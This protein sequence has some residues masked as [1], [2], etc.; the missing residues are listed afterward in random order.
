M[1][2]LKLKKTVKVV[3]MSG[4]LVITLITILFGIRTKTVFKNKDDFIY[5]NDYIFDNYLPVIKKEEVL[6]KPFSSDNISIYKSFYD[7]DQSKEKQEKSLIY[8]ENI[9]M[10]N[11]GV[12]YSSESE[13]NVVSTISGTVTNISEDKLLGK[14]IEIKNSN[15]I[16]TTYQSLSEINVKKSDTVSQGQIIGKSGNCALYSD[17]KNGLH[18]ELFINGTVVDPEAYYDKNL[19][20]VLNKQDEN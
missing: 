19:S 9:Y 18:F 10:Q 15:G 2:R 3:L 16:T 5:T 11:S 7:K 13:F 6:I 1:K 17:I 8:Y 12:D 4:V 14:T 20:E